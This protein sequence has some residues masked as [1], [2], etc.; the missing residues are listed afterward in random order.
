MGGQ[1]G[2]VLPQKWWLKMGPRAVRLETQRPPLWDGETPGPVLVPVPSSL[3]TGEEK[4]F[5]PSGVSTS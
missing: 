2:A 4:A 5:F 3:S 1:Q